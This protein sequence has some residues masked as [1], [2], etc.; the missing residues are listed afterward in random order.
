MDQG[1]IADRAG[2][3]VSSNFIAEVGKDGGFPP[4]RA[5]GLEVRQGAEGDQLA[6]LPAVEVHHRTLA[7]PADITLEDHVLAEGILE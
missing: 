6:G 1:I 2:R 7:I 3:R 4:L 5:F